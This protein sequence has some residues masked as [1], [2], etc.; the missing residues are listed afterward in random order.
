MAETNIDWKEKAAQYSSMV[1]RNA[2]QIDSLEAEIERLRDKLRG[3]EA[4]QGPVRLQLWQGTCGHHWIKDEDEAVDC[5]VCAL[6][7]VI[8]RSGEPDG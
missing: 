2:E 5:P 7:S 8:E 4:V 3:I 1:A 6:G